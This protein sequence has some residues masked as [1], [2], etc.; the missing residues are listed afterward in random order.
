MKKIKFTESQIIQS[1]KA[2][3]GGRRAEDISREL[4]INRATFYEWKRKYSGMDAQHLRHMKDLE[5]ENKRLKSMY[6]D[7]ALD[8]KILKDVLSKKL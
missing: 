8:Y 3:E 4:G 2:Y 5:E 6:A 7:L 1:I